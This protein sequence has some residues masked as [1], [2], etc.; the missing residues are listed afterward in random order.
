[1][2]GEEDNRSTQNYEP[3]VSVVITCRN[4]GAKIENCIKSVANQ[5]Y[6]N[7]EIIIIDAKSTDGTFEKASNLA[8]Y[9]KSRENC[10]RYLAV[11]AQAE[12]PSKGRNAGVRM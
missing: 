4:E 1:M 10:K 6:S 9:V 2:N 8:R 11:A 5:S 12:T 7:F 3:L